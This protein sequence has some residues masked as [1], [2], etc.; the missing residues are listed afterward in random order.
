MAGNY[1]DGI[2]EGLTRHAQCWPSDHVEVVKEAY[3]FIAG[4]IKHL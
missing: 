2:I 4:N 3:K 1:Y